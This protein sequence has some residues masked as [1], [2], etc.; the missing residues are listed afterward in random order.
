MR[1]Q[2]MVDR[3]IRQRGVTDAHVLDAMRT[4]PR[5]RFLPE[6]LAESAYADRALPIEEG[7]T[8][9]QPLIVAMM[10]AAAKLTPTSRV[11]E[12]G[13][14][15]GYG[16]AVLGRIADE[17]WTIERHEALADTA[18]ARLVALGADNVHVVCGDGTL[19]LPEHAP[20][21]AII[22]TAAAPEIPEPLIGQ[23][24]DGGRLIMPVGPESRE[25]HLLRV[26]REGHDLV[27]E[28]LGSVRFVPL[29]A[30][31]S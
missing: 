2:R 11:L 7:Q 3:E 15:S 9:S 8:I 16:A 17:V 19:G 18:R 30:D 24:A 22:V 10:A 25:Q 12:V 31:E 23:L 27:E 29:I 5:E 6:A 20:F 1:R 14:G 26:R 28:D 21:D 4:V 13:A